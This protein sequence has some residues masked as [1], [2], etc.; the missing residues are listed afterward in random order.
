MGSMSDSSS[1]AVPAGMKP[2]V[3]PPMDSGRVEARPNVAVKRPVAMLA[4]HAMMHA[5]RMR[6]VEPPVVPTKRVKKTTQRPPKG[7]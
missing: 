6:A 3:I 1:S 2:R 7:D 4:S 5:T